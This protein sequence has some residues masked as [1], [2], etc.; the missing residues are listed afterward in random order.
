MCGAVDEVLLDFVGRREGGEHV[1]GR[2]GGRK[3]VRDAARGE[4]GLA[5]AEAEALIADLE[6]HFAFQHVEPFFL[7]QMHMQSRSLVGQKIALLDDEEVT[8]RVGCDNFEGERTETEGVEM[9]GPVF[10]SWNGVG[11]RGDRRLG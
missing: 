11:G 5:S 10:A 9:A 4:D 3:A 2:P 1:R 7:G 6:A 8:A